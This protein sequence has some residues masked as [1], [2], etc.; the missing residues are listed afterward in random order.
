MRQAVAAHPERRLIQ[1]RAGAASG[2]GMWSGYRL[3]CAQIRGGVWWSLRTAPLRAPHWRARTQKRSV[4][5]DTS[6]RTVRSRGNLGRRAQVGLPRALVGRRAQNPVPRTNPGYHAQIPVPR[7]Q[8]RVTTHKTPGCRA[9]LGR[10]AQIRV[11]FT[12]KSGSPPLKSRRAQIRLPRTNRVAAHES[13]YRAQV[14]LPRANRICRTNLGRR[15]QSR[16]AT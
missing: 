1:H 6:C 4:G 3:P 15:A 8:I 10:R 7:A 5:A 9:S 11:C 2:V 13:S 14:G 12:N 16:I